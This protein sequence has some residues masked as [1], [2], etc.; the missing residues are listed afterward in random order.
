MFFKEII[1]YFFFYLWSLLF[2]SIF[3]LVRFFSTQFTFKLSNFWSN[4]V[5][6]L[7]KL[8][9]KIDFEIINKEYYES[10]KII[11]ASN[12]QSAW[13]TFFLYIFFKNPIFILK[14][15]LKKIP[16]M[17]NYFKKLGF[18]FVDRESGLKSLRDILRNI[19]ENKIDKKRPII[20]FPEGTRVKP[21]SKKELA[22]GVFVLYKHLNLNILPIAHNAGKFWYNNRIKK[23]SGIIKVKLFPLIKKGHD[24]IYVMQKLNKY[25]NTKL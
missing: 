4:S 10:Q 16:I 3:S 23:K 9:L 6:K 17:S 15:E 20:I 5:I 14:N 2:F 1:F 18:I 7:S 12:H 21:G 25:L 11:V 19:K 8:I 13:E 24:K 22:T